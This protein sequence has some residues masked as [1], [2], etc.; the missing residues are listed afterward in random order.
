MPCVAFWLVRDDKQILGNRIRVLEDP[1]AA[2]FLVKKRES[3]F[4][5]NINVGRHMIHGLPRPNVF[6]R[7]DPDNGSN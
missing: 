3:A 1:V 4:A 6:R 2:V 7:V 5:A